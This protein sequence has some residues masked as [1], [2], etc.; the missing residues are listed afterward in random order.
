MSMTSET[1]NSRELVLQIRSAVT[2]PTLASKMPESEVWSAYIELQRRG[3]PEAH[4]R[5]IQALRSLHR[6]R[7]D[8]VADIPLSDTAPREHLEAPDPFLGELFKA[9]K[10]CIQH[11]R[12]GSAAKLIRDMESQ[13]QSLA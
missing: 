2:R 9:Y 10:K 13:I 1:L 4:R 12:W 11:T 3:E 6:R 7:S 8:G 5:F